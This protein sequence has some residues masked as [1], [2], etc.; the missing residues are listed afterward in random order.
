[1]ADTIL[2]VIYDNAP[3]YQR[4]ENSSLAEFTRSIDI[5]VH[6]TTQFFAAWFGVQVK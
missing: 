6:L 3:P 2:T 4:P 1:M 5:L